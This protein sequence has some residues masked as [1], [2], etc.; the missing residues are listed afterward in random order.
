MNCGGPFPAISRR[1]RVAHEETQTCTL[2]PAH[3]VSVL[4]LPRPCRRYLSLHQQLTLHRRPVPPN[5]P[6]S[7]IPSINMAWSPEG[8][9]RHSSGKLAVK[10]TKEGLVRRRLSS[11]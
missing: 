10:I 5:K 3:S 11:V 6:L 1:S 7:T 9:M 8:L 4:Q 2:V